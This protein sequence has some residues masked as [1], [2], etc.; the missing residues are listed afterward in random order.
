MKANNKRMD[1]EVIGLVEDIEIV[2]K[3]TIRARALFDTGAHR[4]SVDVRLAAKA[5]LGPIIKTTLVKNPGHQ[6][7]V[8][9]PIV[10]ATINIKGKPFRIGV[11]IQDRSHMTFPVIIGRDIIS[12]G[13][14]A[15]DPNKNAALYRKFM[16]DKRKEDRVE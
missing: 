15:I 6:G 8:R 7:E 2:G 1:R 16:E 5:R 4:T 13:K 12:L 3:K 14:F 9:R 10:E 11:N